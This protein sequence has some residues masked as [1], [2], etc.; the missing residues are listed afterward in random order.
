MDAIFE[1]YENFLNEN[2]SNIDTPQA[3]MRTLSDDVM[4]EAYKECLLDGFDGNV[5]AVLNN[6]MDRQRE[7]VLSEGA[8]VGA[9]SVAS[10]WT[11]LSFPILVDIYHEPIIAELCNVYPIDKPVISIPRVRI[12]SRTRSYDGSSVEESYMPTATKLIRA[13][14]V[15]ASVAPNTATN[16][17]TTVGLSS[18]TLV[19]NRRYTLVTK[20][21]VTETD[22]GGDP[23]VHEVGVN[24]R[25]DNR[26]QVMQTFTFND[27]TGELVEGQIHA[28]IDYQS[29]NVTMNCIFSGGAAGAS[30][31]CDFAVFSLR[32]RPVN[33]MNGRTR[34]EVET[35]MNDITVDPNEDF[36]IDLT[37]EDMQ[38]Y[39]SIFKI[40]L[41]RTLSEAIKRQVL[42]NKDYDL[43]YFLNASESDMEANGAKQVMN[44]A[45]MNASGGE[46]YPDNSLSILRNII[47]RISTLV[48]TIRRNYNMYPSY[49]VS[50][51]KT[52]SLLRSL[53]DMVTNIPN[54]RGE[55]GFNGASSQFMKLKVLE[56]VAIDD[57]KI[58]MSTK[59][60]QNAL[61]KSSIIDLIFRPL[62]VVKEITDG[63]TRHFVRSR[64]MI[65]VART[66]GM[67]FIEVR[68]MENYVG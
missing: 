11:V 20:I 1:N 31:E 53:Q 37:E 49:L 33:T 38:D 39:S 58:Y 64:T 14:F 67:G 5:K 60:P 21:Q 44:L 54:M 23:H 16:L 62:Y 50:G 52:A 8:N 43:A 30:F 46:Y 32:F 12:K 2:K 61:E 13:G 55:L 48:S 66:D 56:S 57:N 19:M 68:N 59:A 42:L 26:N 7:M 63:N 47:P 18:D 40:D 4:F 24:F 45:A 29:G 36:I 9:S 15:E 3:M 51:L 35:S 27:S 25:P 65:E 28:N 41:V 6:I 17:F 10:G 34:V 22:G